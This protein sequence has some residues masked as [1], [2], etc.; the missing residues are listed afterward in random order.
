M[1]ATTEDLCLPVR[2]NVTRRSY[3]DS[4]KPQANVNRQIAGGHD[5]YS[6]AN[7]SDLADEIQV[8]EEQQTAIP[9]RTGLERRHS[10]RHLDLDIGSVHAR[11]RRPSPL[12]ERRKKDDIDLLVDCTDSS[13]DENDDA[14][15]QAQD[16]NTRGRERHTKPLLLPEQTTTHHRLQRYVNDVDKKRIHS[17]LQVEHCFNR[18]RH[19]DNR[20]PLMELDNEDL[21]QHKGRY[22]QSNNKQSLK[23]R[24]RGSRLAPP[25][26]SGNDHDTMVFDNFEDP[27][28][29]SS[30]SE[31]GQDGKD[32][33]DAHLHFVRPAMPI[34]A[35]PG[36]FAG[37]EAVVTPPAT[38]SPDEKEQ[39]DDIIRELEVQRKRHRLGHHRAVSDLFSLPTTG[40]KVI[41]IRATRR[42]ATVGSEAKLR[43]PA[44][45]RRQSDLTF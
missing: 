41:D 24:R 30:A 34:C 16:Q 25:S 35:N 7:M 40:V 10:D 22:P 26:L 8:I 19:L 1:F 15:R 12:F 4:F 17:T 28:P 45:L 2:P 36:A 33:F 32:P 42:R 43:L 29:I 11:E 9:I 20:A 39:E 23:H 27:S 14:D 44:L 37:L 6:K 13:D 31:Q 5:H 18:G 38:R 21:P 3:S